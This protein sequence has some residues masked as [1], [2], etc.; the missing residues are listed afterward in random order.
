MKAAEE[1]DNGRWGAT[2]TE[3]QQ[4][5]GKTISEMEWAK[6]LNIQKCQKRYLVFKRGYTETIKSTV[7]I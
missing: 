7:T 3:S 1:T 4:I 5:L 2:D 6:E